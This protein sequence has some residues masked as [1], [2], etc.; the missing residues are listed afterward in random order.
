MAAIDLGVFEQLS[1][2]NVRLKLLVGDEDVVDAIDLAGTGRTGG[3]GGG[4]GD[5]VTGLNHSIEHCVLADAGWPGENNND[6]RVGG[7]EVTV[8]DCGHVFVQ[9]SEVT[10]ADRGQRS[11][12]AA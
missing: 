9:S 7:S 4:D 5:R 2:G 3:H 1:I 8:F 11:W 12:G 6:G 10:D